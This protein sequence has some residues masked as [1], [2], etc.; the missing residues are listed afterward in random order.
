M[1]APAG[2]RSRAR[3]S[4]RPGLWSL[5]A[6]ARRSER[7]RGPW[8]A[9]KSGNPRSP[10]CLPARRSRAWHRWSHRKAWASG[11]LPRGLGTFR[12]PSLCL[13]RPGSLVRLVEALLG[14]RPLAA[15]FDAGLL[16]A[17]FSEVVELRPADLA[18]RYQ[19][20]LGDGWRVQRERPLYP[21]PEGHLP[22]GEGLSKPTSPSPDDQALEDL[23]PL[24]SGLC[25]TRVYSH[26]I[27]RPAIGDVFAQ[28]RLFDEVDL[29][30]YAGSY[31]A[32]CGCG[33]PS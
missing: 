23:D 28:A 8:S 27:A 3:A 10:I 30:H 24:A 15:F 13:L 21:H 29:V 14:R 18:P 22:H 19:F 4:R 2:R 17:A 9:W 12:V 1:E 25:D 6:M 11:L 16:S 20:D 33:G 31:A 26:G 5:C 32:R 7:Q